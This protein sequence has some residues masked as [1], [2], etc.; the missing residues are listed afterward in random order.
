VSLNNFSHDVRGLR[1][2]RDELI[3]YFEID[4]VNLHVMCESEHHM[5]ELDLLHLTLDGYLLGSSFCRQILQRGGVCIFV[6]RVHCSNKIDISHHCKEQDL[7]ICAVQ[8]QTKTCNL[9]IPSLYRSSSGDFNR[10]LRGLDA[11]L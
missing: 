5:V 6:K 7:E 10:F 2:K 11:T 9:N 4:D 8:L 1:N 3:H